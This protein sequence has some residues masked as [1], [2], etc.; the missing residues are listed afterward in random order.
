M[1]SNFR[2]LE[3][4]EREWLKVEIDGE[5]VRVAAGE[6][7]AAAILAS[8]MQSCRT[9]H[10]SGES[11]APFCMMGVCFECLIEIDGIPNRQSCLIP[12]KEGMQIR[13]QHGCGEAYV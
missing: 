5:M 7:V 6:S 10:L 9:S 1:S 3:E 8:G 11:R 13:R 12:V 2:R 4:P